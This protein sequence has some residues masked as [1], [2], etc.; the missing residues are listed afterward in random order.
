MQDA[1]ALG[2][3]AETV[4]RD[5]HGRRLEMLEQIEKQEQGAVQEHTNMQWGKGDQQKDEHEEMLRRL[6]EEKHTAFA[7]RADDKQMNQSMM[8]VSTWGDPMAG[9]VSVKADKKTEYKGYA[10]PNR[11]KIRPSHKWDGVDRSNG[12]EAAYFKMEAS[13]ILQEKLAYKM[14]CA[15]M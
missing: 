8:E 4:R 6:E 5:R 11:F 7:R 13:K 10:P 12:F 15:D 9:L 1:E 2:R 3:G 14:G